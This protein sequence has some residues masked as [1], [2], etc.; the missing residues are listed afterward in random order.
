MITKV[1]LVQPYYENIWEPIGLGYIASYL[2]KHFVGELELSCFQG[3]FDT[4]ETIINNCKD[5]DVV[6]F[7]CTS[8]AYPHALRLAKS[9][10]KINPK[11]RTVVGGFHPSALPEECASEEFIDQVVVGEGEKAFLDIVNG[12]T[13]SIVHGTKLPMSELPW[14]DRKIIKNHRTVALCESMNTKRIASF[15]CNRVCPVNCAFCAERI[16]SGRYNKTRNPIR[17]RDVSELCDEIEHVIKELDLNYFKF[18][19]ATFDITPD[20]VIEFCKEKIKRGITT[21]WEC[22]IHCSFTTEE[23]FMWLKKAQCHQVNMGVESGSNKILRDIGKGLQVKT[24]KKAFG[25]AKKHG[26]ER[27]GFFL[28]G[29][30]NE[31]REDLLLTEALIDEIEPDV[32]GFTILCPYPGTKLYDPIKHKDVDWE[33]ADEYSN[34]FWYTEH[35]SNIELKAQQAYFKT[36]YDLKLCE[37]Q[38]DSSQVG[39]F[40]DMRTKEAQTTSTPIG[41]NVD[42][43]KR[44]NSAISFAQR[45]KE[46][47]KNKIKI[48]FQ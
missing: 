11:V 21:E 12:N 16:V 5:A 43:L 47:A 29:M 8:P 48:E 41:T 22:L 23:M 3:N 34:D 32:V 4:D 42:F 7:S 18:V 25:W 9:I 26:I 46:K 19:D 6:G 17:S 31:T 28:F 20:F 33:K 38:E 14:P 2:K 40:G 30:P 24:I 13:E 39:G 44:I 37:R 27:R 1:V 35:F 36:K 15:Q 45:I 10:K